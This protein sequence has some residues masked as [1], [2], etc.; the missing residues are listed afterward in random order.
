[1]FKSLG[2]V[3]LTLKESKIKYVCLQGYHGVPGTP[4]PQ[5]VFLV[6]RKDDIIRVLSLIPQGKINYSL[7]FGN[8][9]SPQIVG[10]RL[11]IKGVGY[12]PERFETS[13]LENSEILNDLRIP[14]AALRVYAYL[15]WRIHREGWLRKNQEVRRGIE[16]F[17]DEQV[18][19]GTPLRGFLPS[20]WIEEPELET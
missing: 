20:M 7:E 11:L 9:D 13:L 10:V 8:P 6:P 4:P 15:Y 14:T 3:C 5:M 16:Q 19:P 2:D 18:G 17:L 1:M 12:F